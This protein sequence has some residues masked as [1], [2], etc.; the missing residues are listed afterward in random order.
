LPR[1]RGAVID[2]VSVLRESLNSTW[3]ASCERKAVKRNP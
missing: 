2:G 1:K 3:K